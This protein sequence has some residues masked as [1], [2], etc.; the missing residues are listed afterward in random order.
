MQSVR[1]LINQSIRPSTI[2]AEPSPDGKKQPSPLNSTLNGTMVDC[3]WVHDGLIH[4]PRQFDRVFSQLFARELSDGEDALS[5]GQQAD[6]WALKQ[7][8][9]AR[10]DK[11]AANQ[12]AATLELQSRYRSDFQVC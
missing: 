1:S 8:W 4:Q 12:K 6:S 11:Q 2:G 7:F 3:R 9:Q 10:S 5:A